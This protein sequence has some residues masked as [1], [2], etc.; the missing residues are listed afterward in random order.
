M[1]V[2]LAFPYTT[3]GGRHHK[4]DTTIEVDF[5]EGQRLLLGG[6]ARPADKEAKNIAPS[7]APEAPTEK[8]D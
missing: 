7:S 3:P 4:P 6:L 2:T 5:E 8:K 1:K